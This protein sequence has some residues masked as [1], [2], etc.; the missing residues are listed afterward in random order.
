MC[1]ATWPAHVPS[2]SR[3]R[4]PPACPREQECSPTPG[5]SSS[6]V[7]LKPAI[8]FEGQS[9]ERAEVDDEPDR[10]VVG[11]V[12]RPAE[13]LRLHDLQVGLGG[14]RRRPRASPGLRGPLRRR[15]GLARLRRGLPRRRHSE[16]SRS[17]LADLL[18]VDQRAGAQVE[19]VARRDRVQL[20]AGD[21]HRAAPAK[22]VGIGL[23]VGAVDHGDD[24]RPMTSIARFG[25]TIAHVSSSSPRPMSDG[26]CAIAHSSRPR[27]RA[28]LEV[29]ID[30][31]PST[32][33]R[34]A[35]VCT[36][37]CRGVAPGCPKAIMCEASALAP[38]DVPAI[39]APRSW[40]R[41]RAL[42][43]PRAGHDRGQPQLVAPGEEDRRWRRSGAG[44][45]RA[46]RPRARSCGCRPVDARRPR[47]RGRAPR[48]GCSASSPISD[49]VA[50]TATLASAPP[51]SRTNR[52][53]ICRPRSLSSAPPISMIG[54]A[55]PTTGA[56]LL[57][58]GCRA[59]RQV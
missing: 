58:G 36:L 53:R 55:P 23:H 1:S 7:S 13:D 45:P 21:H 9:L 27:R 24:P 17:S 54:P 5:S 40:A 22:A 12:V 50:I 49:A 37:P 48:R 51:A 4:N 3:S 47:A 35:A 59:S 25:C 6:R 15:L 29:L 26:D 11:E 44:R 30:D 43:Q 14:G 56:R 34:P 18:L 31:V 20:G 41:C 57:G 39:A 52:F 28:L 46:C 33:S 32:R 2:S 38:A 8:V 19:P 10:R 16:A 42:V